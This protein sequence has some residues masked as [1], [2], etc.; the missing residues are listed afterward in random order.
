MPLSEETVG[1][2]SLSPTVTLTVKEA[3]MGKIK[4]IVHECFAGKQNP[5][6]VF[7]AVFLSS[8]AVLTER[9]YHGIIAEAA[10]EKG[11][12]WD[13][14][15]DGKTWA[16]AGVSAACGAI[17]GVVAASGV[18]LIGASVTGAV[19]GFAESYAHKA[20][21]KGSFELD[22]ADWK[23]IGVSTA[24][25]TVSGLI[26]GRGAIKGDKYMGRQVSLLKS[27]LFTSEAGKGMKFYYKMT[28]NMSKRFIGKT[29]KGFVLGFCSNK[30]M[31]YVVQES[32]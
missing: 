10:S 25:G 23:E 27:K 22:S 17:N 26:G 15:T 2:T 32:F 7:T 19:T 5:E 24:I 3:T 6:D 28:A 16:K 29:V 4:L 30:A 31:T 9:R 14:I 18:G 8:A 12:L 13:A 21:D 1:G 11:S 20:I